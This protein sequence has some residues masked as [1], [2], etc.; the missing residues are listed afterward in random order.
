MQV[1]Q[2]KT[3]STGAT[4]RRVNVAPVRVNA[5]RKALQIVNFRG[6]GKQLKKDYD[7]V[8][9]GKGYDKNAFEVNPVAPAFTRRRE[10]FIGRLAMSGFLAAVI[11][12][13]ITGKGILGQLYLETN[14]PP[15]A[16]NALIAGVGLYSVAGLLNPATWSKE[17]QEDVA[18]RPKGAVQDPKNIN[19]AAT[20]GKFLGIP[21]FEPGFTKRNELLV[22]RLAMLGFF[23]ALVGEKITHKGALGQIGLLPGIPTNIDPFYASVALAVW[24]VFWGF[25]AV[26][27]NN[28]GQT[29]GDEDIY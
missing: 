24:V 8:T 11:G 5:P 29:E 6:D 7:S 10:V 20:P 12:E 4:V 22:G 3:L 28:F 16:I 13:I 9:K 26:G 14:L 25:S 18:K 21:G 27:Y 1:M 19:A 2:Q 15:V 23:A 17:N